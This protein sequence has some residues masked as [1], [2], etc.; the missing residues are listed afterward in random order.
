MTPEAHKILKSFQKTELATQKVELGSID[1]WMDA[2][3]KEAGKLANIKSK[4]VSAND[5][6][7]FMLGGLETLPKVGDD[8]IAK[9]KDLGIDSE[10]QKVQNVKS[11]IEGLIKSLNP[12]YKSISSSAAKI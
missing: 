6:L 1:I 2:Y 5:E 9:M 11:A 4:I 8:L 10:L 3:K 12:I 7:G